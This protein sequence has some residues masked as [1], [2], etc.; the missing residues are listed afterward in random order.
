MFPFLLLAAAFITDKLFFIG[1]FPSYFSKTG[2]FVNFDHKKILI[3]ELEDYLRK[4]D[5][6]KTMVIFGSSRTFSFNNAYI[7]SRHP[8]WIFFNFSVPGGTSDYYLYYL[9]QFQR[10][11]IKPDFIYFA[12]TPQG[13]NDSSAI[14]MDEVMS[15][16][17]PASFVLRYSFRYKYSQLTDYAGKSL[18]LTAKIRPQINTLI[19]RMKNNSEKAVQYTQFI[20]LSAE[21][22]ARQ[23]GSVSYGELTPGRVQPELLKKD[24]DSAWNNY[25]KPFTFSES[26]YAFTEDFLRITKAMDIPSALLWARV[27]PDLRRLKREKPAVIPGNPENDLSVTEIWVPRMLILSERY[28]SPV[29]NYNNENSLKCDEFFD[30]SHMAGNCF[31]EFTDS[32][33]SHADQ[34]IQSRQRS[35]ERLPGTL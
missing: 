1:N 13:F 35:T 6:K 4:P 20:S 15:F 23:R 5:R 25:L 34:L 33:I 24:S 22:I 11:H 26:Q 14:A 27:A 21:N 32:L 10:R 30:A 16:G 29:I 9:E 31:P 8:D 18:F 28:G 7:D 3:D 12:V 17:L 2:S 19:D